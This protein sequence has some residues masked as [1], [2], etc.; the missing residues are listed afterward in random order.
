MDRKGKTAMVSS[1]G[2]VFSRRMAGKD[3]ENFP[4][5][6]ESAKNVS[7]GFARDCPKER[8]ARRKT[9]LGFLGAV[10][11]RNRVSEE[12]SRTRFERN[13]YFQ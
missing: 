2:P 6:R 7:P 10:Q 11:K 1:G 5:G 13:F 12:L 8:P 4:R 3:T 9:N